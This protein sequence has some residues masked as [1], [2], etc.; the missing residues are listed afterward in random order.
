MHPID[1]P[2]VAVQEAP[3]EPDS[4]LFVALAVLATALLV[5]ILLLW[6]TCSTDTSQL[7]N[8]FRSPAARTGVQP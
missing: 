6:F 2:I 3:H 4:R 8:L 7:D 5:V 1:Q